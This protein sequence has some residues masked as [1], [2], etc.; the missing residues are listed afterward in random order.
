MCLEN[1]NITNVNGVRHRKSIPKELLSTSFANR[2]S[3]IAP[4]ITNEY[5]DGINGKL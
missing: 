2:N 1:I 5:S 4:I 3:E